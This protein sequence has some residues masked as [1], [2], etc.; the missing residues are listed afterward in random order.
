MFSP[1]DGGVRES[2]RLAK[3][4]HV[5]PLCSSVINDGSSRKIGQLTG[6]SNTNLYSIPL[7]CT[8]CLTGQPVSPSINQ[9]ATLSSIPITARSRPLTC[10]F[11]LGI[12][13]SLT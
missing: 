11:L 5:I 12:V 2:D 4:K 8:Y 13:C 10:L 1:E 7:L 9:N 3:A 6:T